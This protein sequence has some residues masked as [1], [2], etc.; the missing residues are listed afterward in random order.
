MHDAR[1]R[2][3]RAGPDPD[4]RAVRAATRG[5]ARRDRRRPGRR[6]AADRDRRHARHDVVDVGRPGRRDRRHR[7]ARGPVAARR[8]R[9]CGRG[10]AAA[11]PPRAVRRLGARRFDRREPAQVAV[12]A[13]RR[14]AAADAP[15][16]RA[17]RPRSASS[18]VPADARPRDAGPRLQRVH[19]A[20]R[21]ALPGAEAV[22]PAALVR[23]RRAA[24][25]GSASTSSWPREFAALGR[26]RPGLGA[27]RAG[28]VLDGLLPLATGRAATGAGRGARRRQRGDHGRGQPHR[29]GLPVAHPAR[30][31]VHDPG[32]RSATCGRS[33]RHVERAWALLREA[34]A[35]PA[36][37]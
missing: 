1:A 26:R 20:A 32:R 28:P 27:A 3:R 30:R 33:A 11:R 37:A 29:R 34:A 4:E 14:L 8:C 7:R 17:A 24:A 25:R 5:A 21:A 12:H 10:R 6:A 15:D 19:A 31:P 13:A 16:G 18:R 9:L 22:D 36:E 23:A 2:A 35:I